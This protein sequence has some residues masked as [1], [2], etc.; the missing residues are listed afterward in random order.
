MTFSTKSS[1][2]HLADRMSSQANVTFKTISLFGT[3]DGER[4]TLSH[5]QHARN[6]ATVLL[7]GT[8]LAVVDA[9]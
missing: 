3:H 7:H 2:D 6:Y 5:E 1:R 9:S 4:N 8:L